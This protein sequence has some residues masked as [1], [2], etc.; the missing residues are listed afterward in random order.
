MVAQ[1]LAL[2]AR[3]AT[4][5]ID[6]YWHTVYVTL[7]AKDAASAITTAL[8]GDGAFNVTVKKSGKHPAHRQNCFVKM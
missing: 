8:A 3:T 4:D 2:A 1:P 5:S 6:I 7:R